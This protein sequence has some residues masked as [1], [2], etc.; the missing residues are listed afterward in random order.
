MYD[1][2]QSIKA[3]ER[4]HARERLAEV[5]RHVGEQDDAQLLVSHL[6][7][8]RAAQRLMSVFAIAVVAVLLGLALYTM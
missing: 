4:M 3:F 8:E 2:N 5:E 6:A 1:D 7:G